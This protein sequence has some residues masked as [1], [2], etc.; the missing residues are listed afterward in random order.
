MR[1]SRI[2]G[3]ALAAGF[4]ALVLA[5]ATAEAVGPH[6]VKYAGETEQGRDIKLVTDTK[7]LVKR[8]AFSALTQCSG[9]FKPFSA[10]ISFDR[11]MK[12]SNGAGFRDRG[13]RLDTDGT[14]SGR[15]KY[16]IKGDRKTSKKFKGKFDLE[17]VFRRKKYTTCTAED[18]AYKVKR[19]D[20]KRP[21]AA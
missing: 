5:A 8:G 4:A 20:R 17:I 6:G 18:V 11:P 19:T 21:A 10:E 12:R 3:I 7:G 1:G 13:N 15:Y 2:R 16:D 9:Q 14:F